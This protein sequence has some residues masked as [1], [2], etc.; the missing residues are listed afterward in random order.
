M[1]IS[2]NEAVERANNRE[3][4]SNRTNNY[5]QVANFYLKDGEKAIIKLLVN[6]VAD[7]PVV[8]THTV[9]MRTNAGKTYYAEVNCIDGC[10]LCAA[11]KKADLP[12]IS[13]A[14]DKIFLPLVVLERNGVAENTY[15]LFTRGIGFYTGT[16]RQYIARFGIKDAIE[17]SRSGNGRNTQ[18]TF[19]PP[20]DISKYAPDK[21]VEEFR[22]ELNVENEDVEGRADSLVKSWSVERMQNFINS[23]S[24]TAE[25]V[26]EEAEPVITP[27]RSVNH[28][29]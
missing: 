5:K 4:A 9:Q 13:F 7:I 11:K 26:A 12:Q 22:T 28:G 27:R 18:Y 8:R 6:D 20:L 24:E 25:P 10:P 15:A 14:H 17:V 29:F 16:I 1:R 3:V 2:L 21:S 19:F 23:L